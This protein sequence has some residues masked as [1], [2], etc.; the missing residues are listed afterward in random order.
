MSTDETCKHEFRVWV[1]Q[2]PDTGRVIC[3]VC[4]NDIGPVIPDSEEE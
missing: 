2:T 3:R 1:G 4:K